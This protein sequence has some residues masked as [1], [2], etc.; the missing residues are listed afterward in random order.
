MECYVRVFCGWPA[1]PFEIC[2][3]NASQ[4]FALSYSERKLIIRTVSEE[5]KD[6]LVVRKV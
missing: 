4:T 2:D 6:I 5:K 1:I 3:F